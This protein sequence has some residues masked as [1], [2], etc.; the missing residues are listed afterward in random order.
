VSYEK[1]AGEQ[2][3]R[4][5]IYKD[6]GSHIAPSHLW[7]DLCRIACLLVLLEPYPACI[8]HRSLFQ[9]PEE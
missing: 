1:E 3:Q 4:I 2:R 9:L 5:Q 6:Q 7:S 8:K